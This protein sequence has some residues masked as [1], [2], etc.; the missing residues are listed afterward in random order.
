MFRT[1]LIRTAA[2]ASRVASRPAVAAA[3]AAFR[4]AIVA[5]A[6]RAAAPRWSALQTVR[7]YS[8]GSG[9]Q[10]QEVE[11]RIIGILQ[12][13]DKVSSLLCPV[14][15]DSRAQFCYCFVWWPY[16]TVMLRHVMRY[17]MRRQWINGY[18]REGEGKGPPQ[19]RLMACPR[20]SYLPASSG[21]TTEFCIGGD[22]ACPSGHSIVDPQVSSLSSARSS[23]LSNTG[24]CQFLLPRSIWLTLVSTGQGP[25]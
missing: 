15:Q 16:C 9:L 25:K 11:D 13:F 1:A 18:Y 12:G 2:Q 4:P 24:L 3:S 23:R 6:A 14:G 8:A 22:T 20:R 5:P 7:M 19:A 10:K 17:T 21:G